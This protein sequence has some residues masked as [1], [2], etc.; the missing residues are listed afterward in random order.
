MYH[1]YLSSLKFMRKSFVKKFIGNA[2]ILCLIALFAPSRVMT[3]ST[4]SL[5]CTNVKWKVKA[6][7]LRLKL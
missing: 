4:R 6:G 2:V 5:Y 7:P 3:G 1:L